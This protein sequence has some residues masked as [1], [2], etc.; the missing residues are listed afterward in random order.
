[1]RLR[2]ALLALVVIALCAGA[3]AYGHATRSER[4]LPGIGVVYGPPQHGVWITSDWR[5]VP[6]TVAPEAVPCR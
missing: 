3:L 5:V 4:C 1:M 6:T 2:N